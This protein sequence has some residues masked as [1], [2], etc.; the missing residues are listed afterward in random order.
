MD[1]RFLNAFLTPSS[2]VIEGYRLRPWCLKH[3]LW[4]AGI[5]SPFMQDDAE[6]G[7]P[8]LMTALKI[9]SEDG[10]GSLTLRERWLAWRL[11]LDRERFVAA[12]KAF[13]AHMDGKETW[14]R[15]W[16]R[17][18]GE[19]EG[20][21]STPWPLLVLCNLVKHGISYEHALQMPEA[22]A[23][24]MSAAFAIGEGAKLEFLSPEME[25]EIDEFLSRQPSVGTPKP[26][27][28]QPRV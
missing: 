21:G 23:L 26:D 9:C 2:T 1:Q 24:W 16:N 19:S 11:T 25:K 22:K 14:P 8:E 18:D 27:H 15:F 13:H 6:I 7:V 12:C 20:E 3:R 5:R 17:K 10:L 4:L 28:E